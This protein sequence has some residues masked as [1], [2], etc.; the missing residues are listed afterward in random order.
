MPRKY[1]AYL[2][3]YYGMK[4]SGDDALMYAAISAIKSSLSCENI[5]VG[6]YGDYNRD[7]WSANT[8][9]LKDNQAFP[10]ENRLVHYKASLQSDRIIFG[11]GSVFHSEKDIN[12]K[13]HMMLLSNAKKSRAVGVGLGPFVNKAAEIACG[14]FLN[15][16]GYIGVRDN[17]S[18]H[19]AKR[20]APNA[21]VHKTFDLAPCLVSSADYKLSQKKR[22]GI[23]L[24]LC[25][26]AIDS[27]GNTDEEKEQQRYDKLA[28]LINRIYA[29]TKEPI[30][31]IDF[32]GHSQLGDWHINN[33]LI[34]RL[35]TEVKVTVKS[36]ERDPIL[37]LNSLSE[38]KTIIS[39]RLHGSILGY[40]AKTPV[41]SI[42]Y[43]QKCKE[44]C[45][46]I[47][48][49]YQYQSDLENVN[50]D[51]FISQII[52]GYTLGFKRPLLSIDNALNQSLTNWS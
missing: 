10:G 38:F 36:Y 27:M 39:M 8:T 9:Q 25:S 33:N 52:E 17:K 42:N 11:G 22:K 20:L 3:G 2:V 24:T 49:P 7:T 47:G 43:H 15:E 34:K 13:R 31:L 6:L 32:N 48:M 21:N 23:A 35:N 45:D 19:I 16:C 18:F 30:T 41:F 29:F 14:K 5:L 4:N 28:A 37:L 1:Q 51:Q 46:D 50:S 26:V 40:L 12:L 44:W